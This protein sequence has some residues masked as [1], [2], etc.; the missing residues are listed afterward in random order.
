VGLGRSLDGVRRVVKQIVVDEIPKGPDD[1]PGLIVYPVPTQGI[2]DEPTGYFP[3]RQT[4]LDP[5]ESKQPPFWIGWLKKSPPSPDDLVRDTIAPGIG[6]RDA[7]NRLWEIPVARSSLA[8]TGLLPKW[9]RFGPNGQSVG[10]VKDE[11]QELWTR[12]GQIWDYYN[13]SNWRHRRDAGDD[14][15]YD[16]PDD[17]PE[18]DEDDT[19]PPGAHES[20]AW[21]RSQAVYALGVN[22]RLDWAELNA[23]HAAGL[24]VLDDQRVH[25]ACQILIHAEFVDEYKKKEPPAPSPTPPA[26]SDSEPDESSPD[27]NSATENSQ[28]TPS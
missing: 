7:H 1:K 13:Y 27:T 24:P 23:L 20:Q 2:Q 19:P 10:V 6:M 5:F 16:R 26:G 11:F 14:L 12:A 3:K 9:W 22:Y 8:P 21:L 15:N 17:L 25:A 18:D 28:S 4:W